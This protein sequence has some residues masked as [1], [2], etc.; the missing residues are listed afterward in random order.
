MAMEVGSGSS[1][2]SKSAGPSSGADKATSAKETASSGA[3]SGVK[4]S[5]GSES[6]AGPSTIDRLSI[7]STLDSEGSTRSEEVVASAADLS[8]D[9][10]GELEAGDDGETAGLEAEATEVEAA[11]EAAE[12]ERAANIEEALTENFTTFDADG[13]GHLNEEE[14]SS[15]LQGQLSPDEEAALA[16]LRGRQDQIQGAADTEMFMEWGGVSLQDV[17]AFRSNG[18][19]DAEIIDEQFA[20]EQGL[21]REL[22]L[23][24]SLRDT[25]A[26]LTEI[27]GTREFYLERYE[28]FR[29]RNPDMEAPKYYTD[30]GLKYF[31]RFH[32]N[33]ADMTP[34][35]QGFVN[36]TGLALQV[37]IEEARAADPQAFAQMERNSDDFSSF[38]Y[39]THPDAYI[40][41]GL[42]QIPLQD[43]LAVAGTPD[44]GDLLTLDGVAQMV[45]TGARVV[46]QDAD[47][48][49]GSIFNEVNQGFEQML[50]IPSF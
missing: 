22:P 25:P 42:N 21:A 7:D 48:L 46:P 10:T 3:E 4:D 28:D 15:A 45:E 17:S 39:G 24:P 13:N 36:R 34:A 50:G 6:V 40:N 44:L 29:R 26:D 19:Q 23:D 37:G 12:E 49:F 27:A 38:A 2:V 5:S 8:A 1:S 9:L 32:E 14:I 41:S 33:K 43:R 35:G 31:D 30:Y 11:Q 20:I 16:T 18:T 47:N